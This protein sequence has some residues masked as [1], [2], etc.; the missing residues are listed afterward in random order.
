[1]LASGK[2]NR[3]DSKC[4]KLLLVELKRTGVL[5]CL[6]FIMRTSN[7]QTLDTTISQ[8]NCQTLINPKTKDTDDTV[9]EDVT[10]IVGNSRTFSSISPSRHVP[11]YTAE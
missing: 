9:D 5:F 11:Q 3:V 4:A 1:M 7:P 10:E 6:F 2:I 8:I